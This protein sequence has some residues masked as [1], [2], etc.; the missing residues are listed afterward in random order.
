MKILFVNP[1]FPPS[2]WDFALSR[3]LEGSRYTHPPLA[4]PTLAALTP[5]EHEVRLVDENVD[6]VAM[7]A[8][9]DVVGITGY[10]IQRARVFELAAAFRARGKR[11]VIGGP[12]VEASTI[13]EIL[14][15]ADHVFQGEAE[16]TWPRFLSDLEQGTTA[17]EYIQR[18]LVD[19]RDSPPPRYDLLSQEAYS[20]ATIE[21]SRGCPMA[22]EFCEI[23]SRLGKKARSKSLE[24]VMAEVRAHHGLGADSIFF[25]DDH[26]IGNRAHVKRLLEELV[27][28]QAE[29]G[30]AMYFT[31][32]FTIN[33]ARD[34]EMLELLHAA[35]FRRVFVGIETPRKASLLSVRKKQNVLGDL[36]EAVRTLQSYNITV[37]AGMIVG[38][39][40]DD[41][42]IFDE[43]R[44]FLSAA[45]I[46]VVM[47]G[48]LQAIP[49]TPLYERMA[50]EGRL[51]DTDFG[52]VRGTYDAL[53][54]T[55]IIPRAFTDEELV[56]GYQR[57]IREIYEY[58]PYAQRVLDSLRRGDKPIAK[59]RK[60]T[61]SVKKLRIVARTVRFY[62]WT[63]D[64][65]RR[66]MFFRVV[67]ETLRHR[68]EEL[69]TALMHLVV[70][71]HLRLFYRTVASLPVPRML[72]TPQVESEPADGADHHRDA[73]RLPNRG[74]AADPPRAVGADQLESGTNR[75]VGTG[76]RSDHGTVR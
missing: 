15:H 24:Q 71:K 63:G 34:R 35:N 44:E 47:S 72:A 37:W 23:P 14:K 21:T 50:R 40:T 45:G 39:D 53:L 16:Y 51:R 38:F 60:S 56:R 41:P 5:P 64:A 3:D 1:A 66:R 46:P 10:Y 18:E 62:L 26:F 33:L 74:D 54:M 58:E 4:L 22:C 17:R 29:T 36:V 75:T 28:F 19:M 6:S 12:I 2:L 68:P 31:C 69:E 52:G 42:A 7:D 59:P 65:R 57:M 73:E 11:V 30:N 67:G 70:Y 76:T 13:A 8:D 49:G 43:Q 48:L 9:A 20:T 32:Q 25:I 61:V 55:N 27:R